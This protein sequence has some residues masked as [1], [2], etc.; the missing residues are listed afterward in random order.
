MDYSQYLNDLFLKNAQKGRIVSQM[1]AVLGSL[2]IVL[3]ALMDRSDKKIR[4]IT[5]ASATTGYTDMKSHVTLPRVPL[6]TDEN[7]VEQYVE[8]AALLYGLIHH[9][10]GHIN[11]T[12]LGFMEQCNGNKLHQFLLNVIEDVRQEN[13]HIRRFPAARR[14][15]NALA[16][17]IRKRGDM[18]EVKT[19]DGPVAAFT[20]YIMYRLYAEFRDEPVAKEL[21]PSAK[22]AVEELF[23][24]GFLVRLAPVIGTFRSVDSTQAAFTLSVELMR[25]LEREQEEARKQQEQ[26]QKGNDQSASD[27]SASSNGGS[28]QDDDGSQQ[29]AAQDQSGK[30]DQSGQDNGQADQPNQGGSGDQ[31]QGQDDTSGASSGSDSS[32][33]GSGSG[34]SKTVLDD[35]LND[36]DMGSATGGLHER[37]REQLEQLVGEKQNQPSYDLAA[38]ELVDD[39]DKSHQPLRANALHDLVPGASVASPLRRKL[40][41]QLDALTNPGKRASNKGRRLSG[42]HLSRIVSGDPRVFEVSD[43]GYEVDTA[44]LV[45]QDVSGSMAGQKVEVASQA[46]FAT[47]LAMSGID[48]L[49]F[50]AMT[51]PGNSIVL[52]PNESPRRVQS[53]FNLNAWGTTP[54]TSAVQVGTR[55]LMQ[56]GKA[57]QIMI[58]LTDG[59]PDDFES[60]A[61]ALAVA[62][63]Q[64]VEIYGVGILTPQ[65]RDLFERW[66]T[67]DDLQEFPEK[68]ST[69]VRE[70]VFGQLAA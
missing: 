15:L 8:I 26:S 41:S 37:A 38:S 66:Q 54:M 50:T 23:P 55:L 44:V 64:G 18:Q 36:P 11:D 57:R 10:V 35:L 53:R 21:Y 17:V 65:Y 6:P 22:K 27:D 14:Y 24:K 28:G 60:T 5:S 31:D 12:S 29:S 69:M 34:G 58:V 16:V 2:P 39:L 63:G 45:L 51:F 43:D 32:D 33:Q 49:S 42:R 4:V 3:R 56:S 25:F 19:D 67:I 52:R 70:K 40:M 30:G 9:E 68:L 47:A 62:K 13:L 1:R 59:T 61:T 48:G 20:G 46:L 7:D